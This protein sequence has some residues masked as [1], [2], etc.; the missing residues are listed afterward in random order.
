MEAALRDLQAR[1]QADRP[2][3]QQY[4]R[5]GLLRLLKSRE[6][7]ASAIDNPGLSRCQPRNRPPAGVVAPADFGQRFLAVNGVVILERRGGVKWEHV[8]G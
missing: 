6:P 7:G 1:A 3:G 5:S 4:R 8:S 2:A